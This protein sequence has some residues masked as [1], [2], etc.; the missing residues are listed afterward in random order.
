[1]VPERGPSAPVPH[2]QSDV[3]PAPP[4]PPHLPSPKGIF[5]GLFSGETGSTPEKKRP[6]VTNKCLPSK[7]SIAAWSSQ[8]GPLVDKPPLLHS[9]F[10][11]RFSVS[12]SN[13]SSDKDYQRKDF[14]LKRRRPNQPNSEKDPG[15]RRDN[16]RNRWKHFSKI[17]VLFRDLR[18]PLYPTSKSKILCKKTKKIKKELLEKRKFNRM[19]GIHME[20]LFQRE[21][22]EQM[23]IKRGKKYKAHREDAP[24]DSNTRPTAFQ[25]WLRENGADKSMKEVKQEKFPEMENTSFKLKCIY[26]ILSTLRR[27]K[28]S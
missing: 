10:N 26:R 9:T 5:G 7:I 14:R 3:C 21:E 11:E 2:Q 4:F 8:V 24:R 13:M 23:E 22:V 18:G 20:E 15:A 27:C 19:T 28:L 17:S 1:M 25:K 12:P 6:K 16:V